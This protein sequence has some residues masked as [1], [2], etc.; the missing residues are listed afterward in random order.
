MRGARNNVLLLPLILGCC[1]PGCGG[2]QAPLPDVSQIKSIH[3]HVERLSPKLIRV[4]GVDFDITDHFEN[5][6]EALQPNQLI[7]HSGKWETAAYL[8]IHE[9]DGGATLIVVFFTPTIPQVTFST[10]SDRYYRGG[11]YEKL[12]TELIARMPSKH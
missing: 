1:C 7:P 2:P 6:V 12:T 8:T 4:D 5:I 3:V 10:A 9:D 11:S